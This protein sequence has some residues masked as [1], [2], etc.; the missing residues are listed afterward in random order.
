MALQP[1]GVQLVAQDQAAFFAALAAANSAV[2]ALGVSS[3]GSAAQIDKLTG[4]IEFQQRSLAIL[5]QELDATKSKY[6][7]GSVQAQ[8]KQLAL[9]KLTAS[10]AK[11]ESA[12]AELKAAE[13]GAAQSSDKL[14]Q[15]F[16]NA[17]KSSRSF[18]EIM[19]GALRKVGELAVSALASAAQALGS[20][21]A[22]SIK[23]AGDYEQAM[24]VLQSTSGAT[25]QEMQAVKETA[26]ALGADLTLPATSAASAGNAMLYLTQQ[27]LSLNDAM[28]AAKGTLQLTAAGMVDEKVAAETTATALNQFH[29]AGSEATRVADLL[30]ASVSASGSSVA[31]TGQAVQQAGTSFAGAHVPL[32]DFVTL[33]N[34]MSKA[35]IK[36]SDAGTS[37]KTMMLRLE[38]PTKK[39]ADAM[40]SLGISVYDQAGA[41]R[42]MR[43]IIGQF[44]KS[45]GGLTQKQRDQAIVTIFGSDA[46]RAANIILA[47]GTDAYDKMR[48]SVDRNG[49][50]AKL[51]GAQMKGLNGAV[52]GLGSQVET[53]ALEALEPLLPIMTGV[54]TKAAEVTG[55]FIGQVGPAVVSVISAFTQVGHVIETAFVPALSAAGVALTAYA[56][57]Q[58]PA[59]I[60]ALPALIAQVAAAATA[61][62]AQAGAILLVAGPLA[63]I[64][65]AVAMVA[66]KYTQFHDQIQSATDALLNSR[67]FWTDSTKALEDYGNASA[68]TVEKLKPLADSIQTQRDLL[69][70]TIESLSQRMAA[71]LVSEAQYKNEMEAINAQA[72]AIDAASK[73]LTTMTNA[74]VNAQAATLTATNATE[75][76]SSALAD[77][78]DQ[79]QLTEKELE[80]LAKQLEKTFK[81]GTQAVQDY[82]SQAASFMEQLTDTNKKAADRVTADQ[83]LAYA[84]QAAAQRAHLGSMLSDYTL[85]QQKL[86]NITTAQAD[87]ILS[88]IEKQFG[89]A[90]DTSARTFLHMEQSIDSFAK[91]GGSS[92]DDLSKHLGLLQ[93]DAIATKEKMDALAKKYTAE[94][95]Q[96]FKDGKIDADE[97]RKALEAIPAK[98]TSEVT[99]THT[100]KYITEGT[101]A[102]GAGQAAGGPVDAGTTYLVGEHGREFF[103]P[104]SAGVI[105]PHDRTIQPPATPA[106]LMQGG[107]Q[108][109]TSYSE[110]R[111][112][113]YSPVYA[114][115]PKAPATDFALMKVLGL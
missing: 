23:G 71:G 31:Q 42:P 60:A 112:Y 65:G 4:R 26:K 49:A 72:T 59:V 109:S 94:L 43:E 37:L 70:S 66:I 62:A 99:V 101:H 105:T 34:E 113:N 27:G 32:L 96:N 76:Q 69:H 19:T 17:G 40:Q 51:A 41:M 13:T 38:A 2:Q 63:I 88:A 87:V 103:T 64:A 107:G 81:D 36:G 110:Q 67:T 114:G 5:A 98:V 20:F 100:D 56:L 45:L 83:A 74:E 108:T 8:R 1:A 10:I 115:T 92:V 30:A 82:V 7:E 55:S 35:G 29:L 111:V 78:Q 106:Q 102:P 21:V 25:D 93:D 48:A 52:A 84:Q 91:S 9:D 86:G 15:G 58:I 18:G 53:L 54:V 14:A 33:I 50:A 73:Q 61:F 104:W 85:A 6:G 3:V 97:L 79:I 95:V 57:T 77:N 11:D 28:A 89:T 24:N 44:E 47:G 80:D 46:Q 39:A 12:L 16:D 68:A 22:S 90:D 75:D